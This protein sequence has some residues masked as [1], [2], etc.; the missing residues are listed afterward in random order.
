MFDNVFKKANDIQGY[1]TIHTLINLVIAL[2][3]LIENYWKTS[4]FFQVGSTWNNMQNVLPFYMISQSKC[5]LEK[6]LINY[7]LTTY[8]L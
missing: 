6:S 3:L 8:D 7:F 2:Q 1:G 5:K 4:V